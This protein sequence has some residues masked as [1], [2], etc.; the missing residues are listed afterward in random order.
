MIRT[1]KSIK[2]KFNQ[3]FAKSY[4]FFESLTYPLRKRMI[5]DENLKG[6]KVLEI[7]SGTGVNSLIL[8]QLGADVL[9][10]D[11][12]EDQISFA[13]KRKQK[14]PHLKLN[15]KVMDAEHL[16]FKADSF[17]LVLCSFGLH[18]LGRAK[19]LDNV[20]KEIKKVLKP[21]GKFIMVDYHRPKKFNLVYWLMQ[22]VHSHEPLET[23]KIILRT[24]F[25]DF[26]QRYYLKPIKQESHLFNL[27]KLW[28]FRNSL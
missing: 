24:S 23:L 11:L 19:T 15:F 5:L 26:A 20:I 3:D 25:K 22:K 2:E 27:V 1:K 10:V 14:N 4:S 13:L 8:A 6:K 9:G 28:V 7:C 16:K 12:S 21:K 17:D 18:E